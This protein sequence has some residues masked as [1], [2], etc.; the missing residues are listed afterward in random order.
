MARRVEEGNFRAGRQGDLIGTNML[1][2]AAR[3]AGDDVS[4]AQGIKQRG[5]AVID[6]AHHRDDRRARHQ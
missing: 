3:F 6:M 5:L 1:G 2:D 4:G